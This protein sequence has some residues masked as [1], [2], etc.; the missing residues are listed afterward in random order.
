[1]ILASPAF[2]SVIHGNLAA[3]INVSARTLLRPE[4]ERHPIL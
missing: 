3:T 2:A 4:A 1:M